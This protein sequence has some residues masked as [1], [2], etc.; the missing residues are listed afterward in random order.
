MV[1][2]GVVGW[3]REASRKWAGFRT[4]M[5]VCLSSMLFI[6]LGQLL[7]QDSMGGFPAESFRADPAHLLTAIATGVAFLGAGTIFRD[8][9]NHQM[10]GLTTAASLLVV[11]SIGIAVAIDKYVIAVGSTLIA[12][13]ILNV[14]RMWES[15]LI[16]NQSAP[17]TPEKSP[18]S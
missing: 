8:A 4:H 1:L 15:K 3:E 17:T 14:L 13:F 9:S 12:L 6:K 2:G 11:A 16:K 7:I 5:M 10:L 18:P